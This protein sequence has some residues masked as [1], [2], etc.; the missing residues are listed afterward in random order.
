MKNLL[1]VVGSAVGDGDNAQAAL[2]IEKLRSYQLQHAGH[3]LPRPVQVKAELLY[4]RIPFATILFMFNLTLGFIALFALIRKL[5]SP[6][7]AAARSF[8]GWMQ[9]VLVVLL[10]LSFLA[11]TVALALRWTVSGSVPL[12]NGYESM[13]SV[14]WFAMLVTLVFALA[15]PLLRPVTVTFGFL[16]S[17]FFLLV[18]H[19]SQMDP[20]IGPVMPVLNSPLLSIHVSIIMMSYALLGLTFICGVTAFV[21]QAIHRLKGKPQ[22]A[23]EQL[24]SLMVLSQIFLYPAMVTLGAGI[25]IGAIWANVSWGAYW[26]WDP[27]ETW[28]LITFMVYAVLLHGRSWPVLRK[29]VVY[30][31]FVVAAFLCILM[32]FFGVNY[33]LGGMHSYA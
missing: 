5:T 6:A 22:G 18:S 2:L 4:N 30:H 13:L 32:T 20:A 27:K 15:M 31:A 28:A 12:S 24:T 19:I 11:L 10:S 7:S 29:P 33:V 25:F 26:S 21:L 3:S 16:V 23:Q 8:A 17:G 14:A 1:P 9:T